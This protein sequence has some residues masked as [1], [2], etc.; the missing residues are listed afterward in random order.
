MDTEPRHTDTAFAV[1]GGTD[2]PTWINDRVRA[3]LRRVRL[4]QGKTP[5]ERAVKGILNNQT[6]ANIASG[7]H[8]P[9]LR[10]LALL[11]ERLGITVEALVIAASRRE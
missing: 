6:I 5:Y 9:S 2:Y 11:C 1:T 4:A 3:E 8:S 7:T 10:T